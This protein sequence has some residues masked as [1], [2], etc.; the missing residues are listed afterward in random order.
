[1]SDRDSFCLRLHNVATQAGVSYKACIHTLREYQKHMKLGNDVMAG[2]T[3]WRGF[4]EAMLSQMHAYPEHTA[5]LMLL[6]ELMEEEF[7]YLVQ[8]AVEPLRAF[9]V[10][11]YTRRRI[12]Q[13][14]Q[15]VNWVNPAFTRSEYFPSYAGHG[16]MGRVGHRTPS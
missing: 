2:A 7:D 14:R 1:M 11:S 15:R 3:V 13:E 4:H 5:A 6:R 8:H 10:R 9:R 16:A 12:L